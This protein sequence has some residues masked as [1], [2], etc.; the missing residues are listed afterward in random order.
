M[1]K[2]PFAARHIG[3][4]HKGRR[5]VHVRDGQRPAV[6]SAALVSA[7]AT[8]ADERIA[9]SLVPF[10]RHP[11]RRRRAIGTGHGKGV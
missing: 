1:L 7:S 10:D 9:A 11:H 6:V 5:A 8:T 2:W 4:G 3:L